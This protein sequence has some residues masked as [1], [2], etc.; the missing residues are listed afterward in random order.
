MAASYYYFIATLP[1]LTYGEAPPISLEEFLDQCSYQIGAGDASLLKY[2]TLDITSFL[3]TFVGEN[4]LN[5]KTG[6]PFVDAYLRRE[7]RMRLALLAARSEKLKREWPA[8]LSPELSGDEDSAASAKA[9]SAISNPF[10]AEL[11][12]DRERWEAIEAVEGGEHFSV[13]TVYAYALKLALMERRLKF[14]VDKG[15]DNYKALY[16]GILDNVNAENA[17]S[18]NVNGEAK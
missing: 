13:N 3:E 9:A 12:L 11:L 6:S 8:Y 14:H 5:I 7:W 17:N 2:C 15:F 4:G 10:E 16:A 18:E 1:G